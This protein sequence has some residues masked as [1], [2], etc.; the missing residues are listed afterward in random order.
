MFVEQALSAQRGRP[1]LR[2]ALDDLRAGDAQVAWKLDR[3]ARS[4]S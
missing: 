4:S 3:L 2:A 1:E